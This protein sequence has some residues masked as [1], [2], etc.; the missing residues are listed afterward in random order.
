MTDLVPIIGFGFAFFAGLISFLSP[1]VV[2]LIPGY[3]SYVSG[4][5]IDNLGKPSTSQLGRILLSSTLFVLG[6]TLVFVSLG[7]SASLLGSL[8]EAYRRELNLVAGGVM[9]LMGILMMDV[10]HINFLEREVRFHP[11]TRG[12]GVLGGIPLGMAFAFGWLPCVGPVLA[13]ILFY[14]STA[15]TM[16]RGT[17]LLLVYSL[18]LGLAFVL[19]GAFFGRAVKALRWVQRH[20]R[21]FNFIGGG[22]LI[23]MGL[24]FI[25]NRFF[26]L[27]LV[28]QKLF[29][30]L[31]Y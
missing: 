10:I 3:L 24:L 25:S 17:M 22:V 28:A 4:V 7:T 20:R 14:A 12:L 9:I 11:E 8:A 29:Y 23:I 19:T 18:G 21:I 15:D 16:L 27:A 26:L 30:K 6:F 2:P 1:C 5:S 31:F 13:S